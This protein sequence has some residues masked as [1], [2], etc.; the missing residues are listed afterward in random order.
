MNKKSETI[1]LP[2]RDIFNQTAPI[3]E[4]LTCIQ[5]NLTID[6]PTWNLIRTVSVNPNFR[7]LNP[8]FNGLSLGFDIEKS[9]DFLD[10][11]KLGDLEE[12]F[13]IILED[14]LIFF[15][16]NTI[17]KPLKCYFDLFYFPEEDYSEPMVKI[18]FEEAAE[19]DNLEVRDV[20]EENLVKYLVDDSKDI[21]E[22]R[23]LRKIQ[24]K[25][26]IVVRRE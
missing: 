16:Q 14:F 26:R 9:N 25:F 21:S 19:F 3:N 24:K 1:G 10:Y 12:K 5:C 23:E 4:Y 18:I 2:S 11:I 15:F 13:A 7:P 22:F 20:I 17:N 8:S 6:M